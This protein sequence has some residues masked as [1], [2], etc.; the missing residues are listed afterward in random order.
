MWA[1]DFTTLLF[2][3]TTCVDHLHLRQIEQRRDISEA[4]VIYQQHNDVCRAN[5]GLCYREGD[6][7]VMF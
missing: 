1:V 3:L 7:G 2:P 4:L 6:I 5:R